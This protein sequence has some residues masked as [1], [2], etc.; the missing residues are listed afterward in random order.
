MFLE[1]ERV[2]L[3]PFDLADAPT[4]RRWVDDAEIVRLTGGVPYPFSLAAE[5]AAIRNE[6][7]NDWD[8][9][10][11]LVVE[12]TGGE[13]P[14]PIGTISL[15]NLH[16]AHR[17]ALLGVLIGEREYWNRGYGEDAVR[18]IC[19]YGFE[20]L[21]LH[22]IGL[23]VGAFNRR[24]VRCYEKVGFTIEGTLREHWYIA[25]RYRDVLWMGLLREEFEAREAART[26][27]ATA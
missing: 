27:G 2:R 23:E 16:A 24:A 25:G 13:I 3:R 22:R 10:V 20:D 6:Q 12:A 7:T 19:R 18:T 14:T 26:E 17:R 5:E 1:G 11:H 4:T 15:R 9:G 8:H 21:D